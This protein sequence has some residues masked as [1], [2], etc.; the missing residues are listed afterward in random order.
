MIHLVTYLDNIKQKMT[1]E[2]QIR[3]LYKDADG[4]QEVAEDLYCFI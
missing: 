2:L 3:F 4:F 1:L